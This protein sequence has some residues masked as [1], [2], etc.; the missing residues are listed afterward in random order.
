MTVHEVVGKLRA[1]AGYSVP[2][3]DEELYL[4]R[5]FDKDGTVTWPGLK[6]VQSI[7]APEDGVVIHPL[8]LGELL[9][10]SHFNQ[11]IDIVK[12]RRTTKEG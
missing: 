12:V 5:A 6:L 2:D 1:E 9:A 10:Q 11:P 8:V 4:F 3:K 7:H